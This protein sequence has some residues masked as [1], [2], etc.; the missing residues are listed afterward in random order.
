MSSPR[1]SKSVMVQAFETMS[2]SPRSKS[3][4]QISASDVENLI[5]DDN[6]KHDII[7]SNS[8]NLNFIKVAG[9]DIIFMISL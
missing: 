5:S 1:K 2:R 4:Q 3:K 8:E 7:D 9:L 6:L